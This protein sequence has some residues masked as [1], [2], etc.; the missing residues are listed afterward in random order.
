MDCNEELWILMN[1]NQQ[2]CV[3]YQKWSAINAIMLATFSMS[4]SLCQE[5]TIPPRRFGLKT[6]NQDSLR[7]EGKFQNPEEAKIV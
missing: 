7:E 6:K 3:I 1:M 5:C 4:V 2:K